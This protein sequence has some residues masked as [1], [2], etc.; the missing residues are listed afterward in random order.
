MS[1]RS[2]DRTA[3]TGVTV[4]FDARGR[5][6]AW[7]GQSSHGVVSVR[8]GL[9]ATSAKTFYDRA[10]DFVPWS[11]RFVELADFGSRKRTGEQGEFIHAAME[12]PVLERRF[13]TVL[14]FGRAR[15]PI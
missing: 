11:A 3:L 8:L 7:M 10:G 12:L 5:L 9:P 4:A 6:L 14:P 13:L 2:S 15:G 1:V